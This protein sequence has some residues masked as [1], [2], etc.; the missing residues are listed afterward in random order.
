MSVCVTLVS[1]RLT[2][3]VSCM[4]TG[5]SCVRSCAGRGGGNY[6][7]C[8]SCTK[9]V[10]CATNGDMMLEMPCPRGSQWDSIDKTCR[11]KRSRTCIPCPGESLKLPF[12]YSVS[13]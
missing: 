4:T 3:D 11:R 8:T 1:R 9:Y 10:S 13:M 5:P 6:Q 12:M 2:A 7:S